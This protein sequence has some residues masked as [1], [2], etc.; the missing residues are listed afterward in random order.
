MRALGF[1]PRKEEIKKMVSEVGD[2]ASEIQMP[3]TKC[4]DRLNFEAMSRSGGQGQ[5]WQ[6]EPGCFHAADGQQDGREGHQGG[7]NE[8]LSLQYRNTHKHLF[9]PKCFQPLESD[10]RQRS[11][12]DS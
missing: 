1:E 11:Y 3:I 4:L 5:F 9:D 2:N 6:A 8:G 12:Y 10:F 7:D